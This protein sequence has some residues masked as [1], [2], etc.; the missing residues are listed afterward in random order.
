[1]ELQLGF[2]IHNNTAKVY[3]LIGI[4][5][6][7]GIG[8]KFAIYKDSNEE[9]FLKYLNV[10]KLTHMFV[11]KHKFCLERV[12]QDLTYNYSEIDQ[13]IS[14]ERYSEGA[15]IKLQ[16]NSIYYIW[17]IKGRNDYEIYNNLVEELKNL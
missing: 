2:Y 11:S 1:M 9:I 13:I 3:E 7:E 15:K 16:I 4:G 14:L 8:D 17:D 12:I 5:T 10:F 6:H